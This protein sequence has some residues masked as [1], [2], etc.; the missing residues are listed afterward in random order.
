MMGSCGIYLCGTALHGEVVGV[1][2]DRGL[3]D[4]MNLN[5]A[6]TL[7]HRYGGSRDPRLLRVCQTQQGVSQEY[8]RLPIHGCCG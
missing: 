2:A 3:V 6:I 4:L 7:R 5:I 8:C 1:H